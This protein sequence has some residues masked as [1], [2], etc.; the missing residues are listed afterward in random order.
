MN[1]KKMSV[2][3]I[4][5][6]CINGNERDA[7]LMREHLSK[8][9]GAQ[10]EVM[11]QESG[12]HALEYLGKEP[13]VEIIVTDDGLPGMSGVEFTRKLKEQKFD[14]PVIFLTASKD[15]N[16]AVEVMKMGVKDYLLKE[17]IASRVF[18]QSILKIVERKRLRQ[19]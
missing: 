7:K 1:N 13:A 18:P 19:E 4:R 6:L 16:L 8:F 5:V 15:V 11:W 14:I 2:D 17:D 9:E 12:E 10:F 3:L